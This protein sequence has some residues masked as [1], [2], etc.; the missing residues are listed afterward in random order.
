MQGIA[1]EGKLEAAKWIDGGL[2]EKAKAA[3]WVAAF[4]DAVPPTVR[5]G[6]EPP[7]ESDVG[8]NSGSNWSW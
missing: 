6:G 4:D 2:K 8:C 7:V 5:T 1:D 3:T